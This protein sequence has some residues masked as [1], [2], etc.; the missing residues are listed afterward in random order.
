[1][2]VPVRPLTSSATS[3]LRFWGSMLEPV[4]QASGSRTQP[5]PAHRA[6]SSASREAW[7][8]ARAVA[9]SSSA[10]ASRS[11][12]ASMALPKQVAKPSALAVAAGSRGNDEPAIAPAPSGLTSARRP[13]SWKRPTSRARAKPWAASWKAHRTGWAGWRWVSPGTTASG[14]AA[15]PA[16]TRASISPARASTASAQAC[17]S[18]RCRSVATWSLRLRPVWS[19]PPAGPTSSVRRRSTALWT[20]SSPS[21]NS[22]RPASSSRATWARPSS[23]SLPSPPSSTPAATRPRTW[24]RLPATSWRQRRRSTAS[25]EAY[26]HMPGSGAPANPPAQSGREGS[27]PDGS[28]IPVDPGPGPGG[29][30]PQGHEA[31]PG[32]VVEGV[33]GGVGGQVGPVQGPLG[34]P[35]GGLAAPGRQ[36]QADLA[37][38][39]L[40]GLGHERVKGRLE[41]REPQAVVDQLG[42]ADVEAG[43]LVEHIAVQGQVLQVA[44]GGDHRQGPRDLVDLAALDAHPAVLH[45]VDPPE[46]H[47]ASGLVEGGDDS[48]Q[49][50]LGP[51]N[52]RRHPGLEADHHL[53]GPAGRPRRDRPLEGLLGRGQPWVL[54]HPGLDGPAPQVLVD[55]ERLGLGDPAQVDAVLVGVLDCL[56]PAHGRIPDRGQDL[57]LGGQ[58]ADADLEPDLVVALAGAAVGH[59]PGPPAPRLLDQQLG[60]QGPRQGR[61]QRVAALV[62]G[63]G[64]DGRDQELGREPLP[65]V[66]HHG[67]A[68]PG[69]Q[70]PLG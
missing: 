9:A 17:L 1:M 37:G 25:E 21:V 13:A 60:D 28:P 51:V 11:A 12:V 66:H 43:L 67:V 68:G 19:L 64:P 61:H 57:Q 20:S 45:H 26:A 50:H 48:G 18:H 49:P 55:R 40:L 15:R 5:R 7:T 31:P 8:M 58:G 33:A 2:T 3:G 46:P 63:V 47:L 36:L 69:G 42:V 10:T 39:R 62:E 24:A 23:R 52:R 44:V 41:G 4:A 22:N 29:Q 16:V 6:T 30:A 14:P 34:P 32:V 59:R 38:D 53:T 35:A 54:E 70:G 27:P 65:A 56:G